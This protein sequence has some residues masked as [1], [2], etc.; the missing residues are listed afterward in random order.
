[1]LDISEVHSCPGYCVL[2]DYSTGYCTNSIG[3]CESDPGRTYERG[4]DQWCGEVAQ[5]DLCCCIST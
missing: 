4:G 3:N 2:L 1:V 5:A